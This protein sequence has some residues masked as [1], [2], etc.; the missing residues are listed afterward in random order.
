M[1][2]VPREHVFIDV[3]SDRVHGLFVWD[4][5]RCRFFPVRLLVRCVPGRDW[6]LFVVPVGHLPEREAVHGVV[7]PRMRGGDVC[8]VH[9][10]LQLLVLP[11]QHLLSDFGGEQVR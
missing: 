4:V 2:G 3:W 9:G 5:L 7:V 8:G 1:R 11:G 10:I 6:G